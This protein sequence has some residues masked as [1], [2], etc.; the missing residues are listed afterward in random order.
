MPWSAPA[1]RMREYILA[2]RAIWEAWNEGT[3]LAFRGEFYRHDLMTPFFR[4]DP[5]PHGTPPIM[6]AGVGPIMTEVAGSV[7]DGFICHAFTTETYLREVTV[8]ALARA[9]SAVGRDMSDFEIYGSFF[10]VA[11]AD[12]E[13]FAAARRATKRQIAFYASTPAYRG[14]L[15]LHGWQDVQ[16]ELNDLA[17]ADRWH[18]MEGLISDEMLAAFAVVAELKDAA[19][20]LEARFGD[21]VTRASIYLTGDPDPELE[22]SEVLD[23]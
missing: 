23:R 19:K 8:P 2:L 16:P 1:A 13:A 11:G 7:A 18:D 9:R 22:S 12:D 21:I 3:P 10:V 14:V 6:L 20:V 4:P 15:E 17:R 5:N